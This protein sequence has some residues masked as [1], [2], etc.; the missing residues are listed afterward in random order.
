MNFLEYTTI[1]LTIVQQGGFSHA[2]KHLGLSNGLISRRIAELE[3]RLGVSLI[4]RTTRQIQL[5]PEGEIFFE[6][7]KR[8]QQE[9]NAALSLIQSSAQKPKGNIRLSAPVYFG[10]HYLMPIVQ[11]FLANYTEVTI[12][13]VLT[14]EVLDPLKKGVDLAIRGTGFLDEAKLKDSGLKARLLLQEK[15]GLYAS[16]NYLYQHGE[17]QTPD[18]LPDH[19]FINYFD[20]KNGSAEVVLN[21]SRQGKANCIT[22][23]PKFNCNDI[24]TNLS[25]CMADQGIGRF[26][27]TNVKSALTR[28]QLQPILQECDWGDY[29]L[30]ALYP[31]QEALPSR[32]R[33]LLEMIADS[34]AS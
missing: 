28:K 7:A 1:F 30:Y 25:T 24:E 8:I 2:A 11:K 19:A 34:F 32:T 13:V 4:K 26:T 17:P 10:R 5:T 33:L 18:G 23:Q 14:G 12:E 29:F 6:H 21:Y 31:Q 15:I 22:L 27:E 9:L 16:P 3:K 20:I